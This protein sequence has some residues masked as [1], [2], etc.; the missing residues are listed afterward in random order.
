[1]SDPAPV[2]QA[3]VIGAGTMGAGIA[4]V[5]A[6]AGADVH[7][8]DLQP[9][10]LDRATGRIRAD[11][12]GAVQRGRMQAAEAARVLDRLH[13]TTDFEAIASAELVVEAV[14]EDAAVKAEV[15]G[16]ASAATGGRAVLATNTSSLLVSDIAARV[17][18][19]DRVVGMHFFNPVPRMKLV[20]VIAGV[21]TDEAVLQL[22]V[23]V[24]A[25]LGKRSITATDGIG[26]I[27]N[28]CG[29]PFY[30]E[31]LKLAQE[32]I[33]P[34][35]QIDRICRL[36]GGFRMG[37]F[38]LIDLVGVDV[39][40]AIARSFFEQSFGEPRWRP[41]AL[42][43]RL[44]A[45][46]RTGRKS[47]RGFYTYADGPHRAP[48]PVLLPTG[49]DG[50]AVH[51]EGEGPIADRLCDALRSSDF[52]LPGDASTAWLVFDCR[53]HPAHAVE[54]SGPRAVLC[55]ATSLRR[56]GDAP[57]A[58]FHTLALP[59]ARA[60][61]L[62]ASTTTDP[63]ALR[64]TEECFAAL[65]Y[66]VEHVGDA[67]GLVLGRIVAQLVNESAFAEGEAVGS[68]ED[69]EV[70]VTVGLNHPHGPAGWTALVGP[71]YVVAVIDGL[72]RERRE[73]RYRLAPNLIAAPAR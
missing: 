60:V 18:R 61:E 19:P 1:M 66:A 13:V 2:Q 49:G 50:R 68:P 46:G 12:D 21:D 59:E 70:A 53:L 41:N 52:A 73:E 42:Q 27:V 37:P 14:V 11:L 40:L 36:G 34:A 31:A 33:A 5:L 8:V 4:Q 28:R 26:F 54:G 65:G 51:V 64:R 45:A 30:G 6:T 25:W 69:L 71:E 9:D 43:A 16:R 44:V 62:T 32:R 7:L 58:G 15:L 56:R 20:E 39:N 17:D 29:R 22:A 3:A 24:V 67:P 72:H 35:E 23:D 47:G 48:D 57:A 10:A 38:E 55:A 63:E